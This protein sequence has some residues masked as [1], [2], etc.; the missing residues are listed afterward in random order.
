M[1]P[2]PEAPRCSELTDLPLDEGLDS[3]LLATQTSFT[4]SPRKLMM[5]E[6]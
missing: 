1:L 5:S 2:A 3:E 6:H 4:V